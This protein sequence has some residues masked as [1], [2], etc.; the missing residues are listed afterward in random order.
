MA[1]NAGVLV[2]SIYDEGD[3]IQPV[4]GA[5]A[6]GYV[7][8]SGAEHSLSGANVAVAA[9]RRFVTS[10]VATQDAGGATARRVRRT[11]GPFDAGGLLRCRSAHL[12]HAIGTT[13]G[14]GISRI[15][16]VHPRLFLDLFQHRQH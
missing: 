7:P 13:Q 10:S 11:A 2:L 12:R 15:V 9:G 4:L 1:P 5:G 16:F 6:S 8:K 14:R 3:L